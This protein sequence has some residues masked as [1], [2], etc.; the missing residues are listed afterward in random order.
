VTECPY[1]GSENLRKRGLRNNKQRWRCKDCNRC[2]ET[3]KGEGNE[4][5]DVVYDDFWD[6]DD[7]EE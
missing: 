7:W 5:K 2:F 3:K 4:R 1:C 6:E